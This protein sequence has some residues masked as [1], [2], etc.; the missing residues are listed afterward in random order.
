MT[1]EPFTN[2]E[3]IG[4]SEWGMVVRQ[5]G[6]VQAIVL[7]L[8]DVDL[9]RG[10]AKTAQGRC[11]W[12]KDGRRVSVDSLPGGG[13]IASTGKEPDPDAPAA[14]TFAVGD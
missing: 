11:V 9:T 8:A 1:R 5:L 6:M 13:W 12:L 3:P 7:C 10:K 4:R 14:G 2:L